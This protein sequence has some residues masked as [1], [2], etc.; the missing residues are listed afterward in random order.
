MNGFDD[1]TAVQQDALV[2]AFGHPESYD[3]PS[4]ERLDDPASATEYEVFRDSLEG[5]SVSR[6]SMSDEKIDSYKIIGFLREGDEGLE[7]NSLWSEWQTEALRENDMYDFSDLDMYVTDSSDKPEIAVVDNGEEAVLNIEDSLTYTVSGIDSEQSAR[8]E[9]S[10]TIEELSK[11]FISF[12]TGE[13]A[14]ETIYND[15][16]SSK[17]GKGINGG[18]NEMT[19]EYNNLEDVHE[20]VLGGDLTDVEETAELV[21]EYSSDDPTMSEAYLVATTLEYQALQA[22]EDIDTVEIYQDAIDRVEDAG[23]AAKRAV[24]T[25]A[26]NA[27]DQINA[28]EQTE[29]GVR[30]AY[31]THMLDTA[32]S[33]GEIAERDQGEA[34]DIAELNSKLESVADSLEAASPRSFQSDTHDEITEELEELER[35]SDL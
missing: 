16:I 21:D 28:M 17:S 27:W 24:Q 8:R 32:E 4:L 15:A 34:E 9:A 18:E 25:T 35:V 1:L 12:F 22:G 13:E 11:E 31:V 23:D 6:G 14:E 29:E 20:A 2:D 33:F 3:D 26:S 7:I 5:K 19:E 10:A 30:D